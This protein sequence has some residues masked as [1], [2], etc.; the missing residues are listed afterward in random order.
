M[1]LNDVSAILWRERNLLELLLFKLE[2]EQLVLAAGRTRWLPFATREV[3]SVLAR[4]RE[5]ELERAIEVDML[6]ASMQLAPGATLRELAQAA[7]GPWRTMFDDHRAAFVEVTAEIVA[8]ADAN[9]ELLA[10]GASA[11]RR[12]LDGLSPDGPARPAAGSRYGFGDGGRHALVLDE[13]I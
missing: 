9:R 3:E 4:I 11:V 12:T 10:H 7:P 1:G 5:T 2:E 8:V 6:A 13:A